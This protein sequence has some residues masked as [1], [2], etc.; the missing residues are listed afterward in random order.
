MNDSANS[1]AINTISRKNLF[2]LSSDGG[3]VQR[4]E[5]E[6]IRQPLRFTNDTSLNRR[7]IK[8]SVLP[9]IT[10]DSPSAELS[11]IVIESNED[12]T[13]HSADEKSLQHQIIEIIDRNAEYRIN[14]SV[15]FSNENDIIQIESQN[16]SSRGDIECYREKQAEPK[17]EVK[18]RNYL[19]FS[20]TIFFMC[21]F[22]IGAI[23]IYF[24]IKSRRFYKENQ[25]IQAKKYSKRALKTNITAVVVGVITYVA[26]F[27][28]LIYYVFSTFNK[29]T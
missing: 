11:K 22:V 20:L 24:S 10:V 6:I 19:H 5:S 3:V 27:S 26:L 9:V 1:P 12:N 7:V 25:V 18:P 13:D 29:K 28:W 15:S 16:N 23:A 2:S 17:P 21:N 14:K 8:Q 4:G